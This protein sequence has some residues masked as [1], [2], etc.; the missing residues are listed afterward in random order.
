MFT[1]II[2]M[3]TNQK[4]TEM[5]TVTEAPE[6]VLEPVE[7][8]VEK[9]SM[10]EMK[11]WIKANTIIIRQLKADYKEYQRGN[12]EYPTGV[13]PL[14]WDFRHRLIAYSEMRGR[15]REQIEKPAMHN[16]PNERL[17]EKYK[18]ILYFPS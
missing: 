14:R 18:N 9:I 10:S 7:E 2:K 16:L 4:E 17:I 13:G 12:K 8:K 11:E 1:K 3:F 5:N 15:T 6:I